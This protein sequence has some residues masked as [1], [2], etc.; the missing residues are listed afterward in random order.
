MQDHQGKR[1]AELAD[2]EWL[3]RPATRAVFAALRDDGHK[4]RAVGGAVRNTLLGRAVAD[5]D[6]ATPALPDIVMR[7]AEKAG[8]KAVATGIDHGT[9]TVISDHQPFEVTTLRKD[10][11]T[12]GR[13]AVVAFTDD[14]AEDARRRDFTMNALYASADGL[15][16]DPLGG[17]EDLKAHRVRFIGEPSQRIREDY[18]R[19]LRFFRFS[20]DY[21]DGVFDP[22]GLKACIAERN[23]LRQLSAERLHG[24]LLQLL[25]LDRSFAALETMF[26]SGLLADILGGAPAL[27]RVG[28]LIAIE[29]SL[30]RPADALLR[31]GALVV[32]VQEDAERLAERFRLSNAEQRRLR[33]TALTT[34]AFGLEKDEIAAKSALYRLGPAGYSDHIM[35]AWARS[36]AKPDDDAWRDL[37][38]LADRWPV[39]A[40]PLSGGDIVQLGI[41]KG[42]RVGNILNSVETAWIERGFIDSRDALLLA[43]ERA[44]SKR[45]MAESAESAEAESA[46]AESDG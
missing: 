2:A 46:E 27:D 15:L 35:M 25:A 19:I 45:D 16:F 33:T 44:I 18:L 42:P 40:F 23:G 24:E 26:E 31:L 39:P 20:A 38:T 37:V 5:I 29:E 30:D 12:F 7:V 28:R 9:V 10:V 4:V 6:L 36:A 17:Y 8:L 1:V 22:D 34:S 11:E 13:R 14:W 3:K 32:R 43:A 41:D 21:G